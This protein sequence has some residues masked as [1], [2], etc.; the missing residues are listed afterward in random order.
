MARALGTWEGGRIKQT[1]DGRRVYYIRKRIGGRLVE[2]STGAT[3]RTAA[4]EQWRRFQANPAAWTPGGAP[5][6]EVLSVREHL[7][8]YLDYC[9]EQKGNSANWIYQKQRYL[10]WWAEV[11]PGDCRLWTR[12]RVLEALDGQPVKHNALAA[13]KAW[14]TW[15]RNVRGS[16]TKAEDVTVDIAI[17]ALKPAQWRGPP[18]A[19]SRAAFD[20]TLEKLEEPYHTVCTV[21]GA[22]GMHTTEAL[23]LARGHGGMVGGALEI[24]HKSG[25]R[26]RMQ[27]SPETAEAV[28]RLQRYGGFGVSRLMRAIKNACIKA[29]VTPWA[30]GALRHSAATW[31]IEA[32][33]SI[34][35]VAT[36][37]NH[38][39]ETLKRFYSAA[40]IPRPV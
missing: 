37:L 6:G 31:L 11:L 17:P 39:V 23:R 3:S 12:G 33:G 28:T 35:A 16:L 7:D 9:R 36:Y 22:T 15:L 13:L 25:R 26:H 20:A 5:R 29:K 8:S 1:S 2:R 21:L 4:M 27:V 19:I 38:D 32:G 30:P 34:E 14:A 40:A 18:R 24:L 10:E